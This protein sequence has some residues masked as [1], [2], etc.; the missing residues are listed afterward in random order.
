MTS[1]PVT[2]IS[3]AAGAEE[4]GLL[5]ASGSAPSHPWPA[6]EPGQAP[7]LVWEPQAEGEIFLT[8]N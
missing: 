8:M 1:T 4:Q 2:D 6:L 5:A 7:C 3:R